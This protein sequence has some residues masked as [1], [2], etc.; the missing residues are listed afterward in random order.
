MILLEGFGH[1]L[2]LHVPRVISNRGT[3]RFLLGESEVLPVAAM[4]SN[5]NQS[6]QY[7]TRR[8][9]QFN[10]QLGSPLLVAI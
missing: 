6:E 7:L 1:F 4:L 5:L 10:V 3:E 9:R 8:T 2:D